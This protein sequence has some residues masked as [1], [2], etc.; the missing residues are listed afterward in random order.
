VHAYWLLDGP[1]P[2]ERGESLNRRLAAALGGDI[3]SANRGRILRVPG[4]INHKPT[5]SGGRP[6]RCRLI[7]FEP[8][9][10]RHRASVLAR[11]LTDPKEPRPARAPSAGPAGPTRRSWEDLEA[12]DYYR[13]LTGQEPGRDGTVRCPNALHEDR[14]PSAHLYP[15]PGR[16]WYCFACGAGGGPV[17]MVAALRGWPTG[18][19]LRG[20]RFA[21]CARELRRLMGAAPVTRTSAE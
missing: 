13:L 2:A 20:E 16:G 5:V 11:G 21:A 4:S 10:P 14:H 15:G 7:L 9:R 19:T 18:A 6:R 3:V 17:D 12:A 1:L 8:S